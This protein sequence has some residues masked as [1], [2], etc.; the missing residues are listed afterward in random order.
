MG[1]QSKIKLIVI[2]F[3]D[4]WNIA[5]RR[6]KMVLANEDIIPYSGI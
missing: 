4:G 1:T 6:K 3:A 2:P 5:D